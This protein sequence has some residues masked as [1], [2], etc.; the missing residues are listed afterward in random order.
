MIE[1]N[2]E[3]GEIVIDLRKLLMVYLRNWW[4]ILLSGLVMASVVLLVTKVAI[5][6][7]YRA[8]VSVYVNNSKNTQDVNSISTSTLS[9]SQQLVNTYVNIIQ[10]ER[11]LSKVVEDLEVDD[12]TTDDLRDMMSASQVSSTEIFNINITYDSPEMAA[13]IANTIARVSPDEIAAVVEGS[14]A[15]IIDYAIVP[16]TH[17]SPSYQRNTLLG[18][19]IGIMLAVA[20]VTL[21]FLLDVRIKDEEDLTQLFT[22]PVLG[23]IPSFSQAGSRRSGYESDAKTEKETAE[24]EAVE[25]ETV[26]DGKTAVLSGGVQ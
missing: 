24:K 3:N 10:S 15:Q 22:I 14:S 20:F 25:T 5:T 12:I 26:D 8:T 16:T 6:P 23:Q 9:A 11:V 18:G 21:G 2:Q 19:V 17:Y 1:K 7:L 4:I 13:E